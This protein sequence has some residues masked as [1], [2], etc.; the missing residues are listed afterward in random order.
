[1]TNEELLALVRQAVAEKDGLTPE[2][3]EKKER[4]QADEAVLRKLD[5]L[6][7]LDMEPDQVTPE[8]AFP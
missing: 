1:M 8:Q 7:G 2:Q 6:F 5:S 4:D 3:R